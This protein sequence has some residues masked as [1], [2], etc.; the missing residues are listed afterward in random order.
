GC[1][2]RWRVGV[3]EVA[4]LDFGLASSFGPLP[5]GRG[6]EVPLPDGRG[7]LPLPDGRGSVGAFSSSSASSGAPAT[8]TRTF[9]LSSRPT[10]PTITTSSPGRA[11]L[12][13][14]T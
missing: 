11:P 9:A 3:V 4:H 1:H 10:P 2:R 5:D 7:S 12:R 6:S 13:I 8:T 14:C